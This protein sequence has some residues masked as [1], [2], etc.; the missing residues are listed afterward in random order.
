MPPWAP[1]LT[2]VLPKTGPGTHGV[3]CSQMQHGPHGPSRRAGGK[4]LHAVSDRAPR[5]ARGSHVV[6][7]AH[8]GP[9]GLTSPEH[10]DTEAVSRTIP[11]L[12]WGLRTW[13]TVSKYLN[14]VA[15]AHDGPTAADGT[16]PPP[17]AAHLHELDSGD[18]GRRGQNAASTRCSTGLYWRAA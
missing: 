10:R 8:K 6:E 5:A 16:Q 12:P 13:L 7:K 11:V 2:A 15:V 4:Q 3:A 17:Q 14:H 9:H 18:W 1:R